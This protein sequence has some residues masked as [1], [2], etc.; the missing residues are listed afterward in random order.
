MRLLRLEQADRPG[1]AEVLFEIGKQL[2]EAD[3]LDEAFALFE[4][5]LALGEARKPLAHM[6]EIRLR[7]SGTAE[8]LAL[9]LRGTSSFPDDGELLLLEGTLRTETGD[10]IGAGAALVR[11][12]GTTPPLI[13]SER[14]G[15]RTYRAHHQFAVVCRR[16]GQSEGLFPRR[17]A[18]VTTTCLRREN[19]RNRP[20]RHSVRLDPARPTRSR[21]WGEP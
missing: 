3:Q 10:L 13:G 11:L 12:L 18:V 1:D 5:S 21:R 19:V 6:T 17:T 4:K 8:A 7:Q 9:C 20:R 2:Q 15:L 16:L 14:V